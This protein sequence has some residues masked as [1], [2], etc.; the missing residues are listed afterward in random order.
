[1]NVGKSELI[2]IDV[3]GIPTCESE[4]WRDFWKSVLKHSL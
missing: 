3:D 1:M 4:N 2:R